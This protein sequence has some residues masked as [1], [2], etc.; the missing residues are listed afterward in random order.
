MYQYFLSF[1]KILVDVGGLFDFYTFFLLKNRT[2]NLLFIFPGSI[3]CDLIIG[4]P[5]GTFFIIDIL[6]LFFFYLLSFSRFFSNGIAF[7]FIR[8]FLLFCIGIESYK[9]IE[10]VFLGVIIC[11][12]FN[13]LPE[14]KKSIS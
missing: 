6:A 12:M 3:I 14:N 11:I 7:Y 13:A 1:A 2:K 4:M 10:G 8:Y 5:I 9:L